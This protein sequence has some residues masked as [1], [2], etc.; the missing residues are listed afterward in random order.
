MGVRS[1]YLSCKQI[2]FHSPVLA[3]SQ[4]I[5]IH[6]I[7][8][9]PS[10][11]FS[12]QLFTEPCLPASIVYNLALKYIWGQLNHNGSSSKGVSKASVILCNSH[13][14]SSW[15]KRELGITQTSHRKDLPK[16]QSSCLQSDNI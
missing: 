11:R 6:C 8:S 3:T 9:E 12:V 1:G 10:T 4:H 7:I 13:I 14:G 15:G 16:H 2:V 5:Q